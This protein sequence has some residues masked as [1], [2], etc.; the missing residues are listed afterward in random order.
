MGCQGIRKAHKPRDK[1]KTVECRRAFLFFRAPKRQGERSPPR[2]NA[3]MKEVKH[4]TDRAG[5]AGECPVPHDG[6]AH[7]G[8][9]DT[10]V[11]RDCGGAAW[12]C[13][14]TGGTA[15]GTCIR[16]MRL[17]ARGGVHDGGCIGH[18]EPAHDAAAAGLRGIPRRHDRRAC[19][20]AG[21]ARR[22]VV[23][24]RSFRAG[25]V[26]QRDSCPAK[27][28]GCAYSAYTHHQRQVHGGVPG[29]GGQRQ[30]PSGLPD[31]QA[32]DRSA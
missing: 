3:V 20:C 10:R 15:G 7:S 1:G 6:A 11:S 18:M 16:G 31:A 25:H 23:R 32:G 28:G 5:R 12:R 29:A 26:G 9:A 13:I 27:G 19:R 21:L 24:G 4:D 14:G 2:Y 22:G 8:A 17:A 30:L